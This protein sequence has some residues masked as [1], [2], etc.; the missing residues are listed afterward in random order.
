MNEECVHYY[1]LIC[2]RLLKQIAF[3]YFGSHI[4]FPL[5]NSHHKEFLY[6]LFIS[7]EMLFKYL[8]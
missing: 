8:A 3:D 7:S 5:T 1:I 2:N 6:P 4:S